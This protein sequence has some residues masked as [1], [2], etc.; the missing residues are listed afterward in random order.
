MSI[1]G[2]GYAYPTGPVKDSIMENGLRS[3]R[4]KSCKD[5]SGSGGHCYQIMDDQRVYSGT[6]LDVHDERVSRGL[7]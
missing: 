3:E 1:S 2:N 7:F 4:G 5:W 6:E